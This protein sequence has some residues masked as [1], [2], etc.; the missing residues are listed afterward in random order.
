[1]QSASS[2]FDSAPVQAVQFGQDLNLQQQELEE[3]KRKLADLQSVNSELEIKLSDSQASQSEVEQ[4]KTALEEQKS[5]I[6]QWNTWAADKTAE[7]N[8][9]IVDKEEL[10]RANTVQDMELQESKSKIEELTEAAKETVYDSNEDKAKEW[11]DKI[12]H[13]EMG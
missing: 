2:F 13:L 1:M 7:I 5:I 12:D 6:E 10:Q 8:Q 11:Q 3:L 4:L 9:L